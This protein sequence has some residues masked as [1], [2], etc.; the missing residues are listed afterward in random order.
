M[1]MR[2]LESV[3]PDHAGTLAAIATDLMRDERTKHC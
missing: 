3:L 2:E 1:T